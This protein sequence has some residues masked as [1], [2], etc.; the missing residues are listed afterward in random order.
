MIGPLG[1]GTSLGLHIFPLFWSCSATCSTPD[2]QSSWC[3][4][5]DFR[6]GAGILSRILSRQAATIATNCSIGPHEFII[7]ITSKFPPFCSSYILPFFR[8]KISKIPRPTP[9]PASSL[10]SK[11]T[12]H[13]KYNYSS[14][15]LAKRDL[16]A[17]QARWNLRLSLYKMVTRGATQQNLYEKAPSGGPIPCPFIF[18][19][20][21]KGYHVPLRTYPL[22]KNGT[23]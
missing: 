7:F 2:V 5:T 21:Q 14:P 12:F 9:P 15:L 19:F 18:H 22:V 17:I 10:N 13:N 20:W 16:D 1:W 3:L 8:Q 23:P 6:R 11:R 4:K